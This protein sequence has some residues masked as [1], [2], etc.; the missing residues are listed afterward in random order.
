VGGGAQAAPKAAG[1]A[2]VGLGSQLRLG[3]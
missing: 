2:F 1:L 3:T